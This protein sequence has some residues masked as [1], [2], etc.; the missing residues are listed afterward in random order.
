MLKA[1]CTFGLVF[2]FRM[3]C[4]SPD[5]VLMKMKL[6]VFLFGPFSFQIGRFR[7]Y[8]YK[9]CF[10]SRNLVNKNVLVLGIQCAKQVFIIKYPAEV[11]FLICCCN[12]EFNITSA[13]FSKIS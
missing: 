9:Q 12:V 3:V 5:E 6:N 13:V 7:N 1:S 11:M 2:L 10:A 8:D 4:G